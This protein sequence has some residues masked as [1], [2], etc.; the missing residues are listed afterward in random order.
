ML[1]KGRTKRGVIVACATAS[2]LTPF[3]SSSV[4]VLLPQISSHYGISLA[5]SNWSAVAYL[6]A[7]ASFIIPSGRIADWKGR[8]LVFSIGLVSFSISSL[9]VA[10]PLNFTSFLALRFAQG[11]SSSMISATA[12]AVIS[13]TFPKEERGRAVGLN[14]AFVYIGLS[15]GPLLG[16]LIADLWSWIGVFLFSSLLSLSALIVSRPV[17]RLRGRGSQ[18]SLIPISLYSASM[19]LLTYGISSLSM[20]SGLPLLAGVVLLAAWLLKELRGGVLGPELLRNRA[21]ISSSSAALLNY[22]ATYAISIVLG[23]YLQ[24]VMGL[25]ASETGILLTSQPIVQALLS[26]FAGYLADR[27]SPHKIASLGMGVVALGIATLLPLTPSRS[28]ASILLSLSI[29]GVGFALF[30]S[31]NTVAAL[32]ASPPGL[33]GSANAFLGS[34]RFLGQSLSTAIIMALMAQ[35]ELLKAMNSALLIYVAISAS[36]VVIS[37]LK[38]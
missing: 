22:S 9:L 16:G 17:L 23:L 13:E 20:G 34:M 36:G 5:A 32:N 25:S 6:M 8:G 12:V 10:L 7:L 14:T 26:P 1:E 4:V 2:F 19:I 35:G 11:V 37:A 24:R 38:R 29:L 28:I 3:S 33:Y 18:P 31:P 15:L 21:Y 27:S 30:A